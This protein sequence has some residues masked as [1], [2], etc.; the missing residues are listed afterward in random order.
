MSSTLSTPRVAWLA[1]PGAGYLALAFALPLAVLLA[2][3]F[4]DADGRFGVQGYAAFFSDV[5]NAQVVWNTLKIA[6]VVTLICLVIGYPVAFA[7]ARASL[8]VQGLMFLTLILPLS[9]GVI[10][11]SFAWTILL[12]SNG[13]VNQLLLGAG[14]VDEPVKLLFN[15]RGLIVAA[16]HVFLPF[17]VLPIFTVA[18]QI[19]SRLAEAAATLGAHPLHTLARVTWPLS[20]PGVVTGC[21][22][23]FSMAVSMYVIPALL[24]GDRY[25]TLPALMARAYLFMRDRQAGSTLAV[26]LLAIAVLIVVGSTW[27]TRRLQAR[28]QNAGDAT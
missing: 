20:L 16:V 25:Q 26:V 19:D 14:L 8:P 24:I 21:A 13:L 5:Y 9:V 2:T 15:E 27:L 28:T 6:A 1:L 22:F 18:R 17:M 10:V 4:Q 3:S 12:R 7:M 23:V 11:K